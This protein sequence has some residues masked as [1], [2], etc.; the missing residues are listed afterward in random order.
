MKC[1]YVVASGKVENVSALKSAKSASECFTILR[2]ENLFTQKDVIFMQFL[3]KE[4]GCDDL[5][6]RCV[7]YAFTNKAL[8]FFETP[9]GTFMF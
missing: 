8:C 5:Y 1:L 3:C 9:P 6:S 4:T 7:R 2:E